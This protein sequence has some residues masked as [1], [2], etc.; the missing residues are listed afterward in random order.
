MYLTEELFETAGADRPFY[1]PSKQAMGDGHHHEQHPADGLG[2]RKRN[3]DD[4]TASTVPVKNL[5]I[6]SAHHHLLHHHPV[7]Y[8]PPPHTHCLYPDPKPFYTLS[9]LRR[10]QRAL[11]QPRPSLYPRATTYP[12][13]A[14]NQTDRISQPP[15][16][17]SVNT[18]A[19]SSS[20]PPTATP[21]AAPAS[22]NVDLTPCHSCHRAP[23]QKTDLDNYD[24]CAACAGRTCY[25]C[26]RM[27]SG[28]RCGGRKICR[29]CCLERGEEGETWC[30]ACEQDIVY[31][32]N[33]ATGGLG[34]DQDVVMG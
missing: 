20:L 11:A 10:K 7:D 9:P 32:G 2:K 26:M 27:C 31:E 18:T 15:P 28:P 17:A 21:T 16:R 29:T 1:P 25:I 22:T 30:F 12:R 14:H 3:G 5:K 8:P 6:Y 34:G 19:I 13:S 23:K 4:Y 33:G 24:N